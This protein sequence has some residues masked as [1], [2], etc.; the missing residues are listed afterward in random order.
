MHIDIYGSVKGSINSRIMKGNG[1]RIKNVNPINKIS[2]FVCFFSRGTTPDPL[3]G[4]LPPRPL[5][6]DRSTEPPLGV[7]PLDPARGT[8]PGTRGNHLFEKC[9]GLF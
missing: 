7:L 5:P 9:R 3:R 8:A 4:A 2:G 1:T 6:A